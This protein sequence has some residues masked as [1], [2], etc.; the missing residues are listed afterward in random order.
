M[1]ASR[2]PNTAADRAEVNRFRSQ[3]DQAARKRAGTASGGGAEQGRNLTDASQNPA[4]DLASARID[5][6]AG[7]AMDVVDQTNRELSAVI[8]QHGQRG[9]QAYENALRQMQS[10][11]AHRQQQTVGQ[12]A[13][14]TLGGLDPA[15]VAAMEGEVA[16]GYQRGQNDLRQIGDIWG[17]QM[18]GYG[19]LVSGYMNMVQGT[20]PLAREQAQLAL[21]AQLAQREADREADFQ[22]WVRRQEYLRANQ[23]PGDLSPNDM[24]LQATAQGRLMRDEALRELYAAR[25][26]LDGPI[27]VSRPGESSGRAQRQAEIDAQIAQLLS[28]PEEH[29]ATQAAMAMFGDIG[30]GLFDQGELTGEHY[31]N[32]ARSE[33]FGTLSQRPVDS[34]PYTTPNRGQGLGA[35]TREMYQ[36]AP[37]IEAEGLLQDR[38]ALDDLAVQYAMRN[39]L[40]RH[41]AE[42]LI[43]GTAPSASDDLRASP[44]FQAAEA[45]VGDIIRFGGTREDL[46]RALASAGA[47][48]QLYSAVMAEYGPRLPSS[49]DMGF[50]MNNMR[51][52]AAIN[53]LIGGS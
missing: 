26:E 7:D 53:R 15:T 5:Q 50:M 16:S 11:Q 41:E 35:M 28:L 10:N 18:A 48:P 32:L 17:Q 49:G 3:A 9:R 27:E 44:D 2:Y 30:A 31:R 42:R 40:S 46:Q 43:R 51:D 45:L 52:E 22:D 1:M 20:V 37:F 47:P 34:G 4:A 13:S 39:G 36:N 38:G 21:E 19:D 14:R 23:G 33:L 29:W 25:A 12:Q 8:A 6:Y 24:K